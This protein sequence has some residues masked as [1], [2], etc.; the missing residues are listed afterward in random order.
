MDRRRL[1]QPDMNLK[2][3]FDPVRRLR[4]RECVVP[5]L[6]ARTVATGC[7]FR[8]NFIETSHFE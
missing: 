6:D 4:T 5:F 3:P 7:E 1:A 2:N 8:V